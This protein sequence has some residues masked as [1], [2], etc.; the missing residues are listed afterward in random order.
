MPLPS[1]RMVHPDSAVTTEQ[2]DSLHKY[3]TSLS[4]EP[5]VATTS[6]VEAANSE[7]VRWVDGTGAVRTVQSTSGGVPF[8]PEYKTWKQIGSTERAENHT[9]RVVL[10]NDRAVKAIADNH[11]NPW[12]DGAIIGKVTWHEQK[13]PSGVIRPGQFV[14]VEFMIRDSAK[15]HT[16]E[17]WSWGRWI[18]TDLKP[19]G[20]RTTSQALIALTVI[21]RSGA[22]TL[23]SRCRS[24]RSKAVRSDYHSR[25][26]N[27]CLDPLDWML[28][29]E[30][31]YTDSA[32]SRCRA[33][34]RASIQPS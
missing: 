17:G 3:L 25:S 2:L 29:A 4:G 28:A 27:N 15:H 31:S 21:T 13:D 11:I 30:C 12:P 18:G 19:D 8:H 5:Q 20:V 10:G 26:W 24:M 33:F 14:Q 1:Y 16:T 22:M 34:G 32:Q 6:Q 9:I 7:Y 23:S